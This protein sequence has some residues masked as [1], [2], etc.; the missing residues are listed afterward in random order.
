M[1]AQAQMLCSKLP[2]GIDKS[3]LVKP[4]AVVEKHIQESGISE[5]AEA[6]V[7]DC[8]N[9][10]KRLAFLESSRQ[11]GEKDVLLLEKTKVVLA[12]MKTLEAQGRLGVASLMIA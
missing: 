10:L 7:Y 9:S 11:N 4:T 8:S 12:A 5:E 3:L 2:S 1:E 6:T